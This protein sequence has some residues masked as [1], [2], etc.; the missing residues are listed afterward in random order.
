MLRSRASR[1]RT[2][3]RDN[4]GV[5]RQSATDWR[6]EGVGLMMARR[7][8]AGRGKRGAAR[9][10]GDG[11]AAGFDSEDGFLGSF[12]ASLVGLELDVLRTIVG[13]L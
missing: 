10:A 11:C 13:F 3:R 2:V 6:G 7:E 12:V 8:H 9:Q 4:R 5:G 1:E